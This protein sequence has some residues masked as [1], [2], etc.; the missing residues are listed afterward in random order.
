ML[1]LSWLSLCEQRVFR[2]GERYR[3]RQP[4]LTRSSIYGARAGSFGEFDIEK[5]LRQN[6]WVHKPTRGVP[7]ASIWGAPG[8][9]AGL[10]EVQR[11]GQFGV[12]E[13]GA[14]SQWGRGGDPPPR[15]R[16][17]ADSS[18]RRV[19]PRIG[20]F[21]RVISCEASIRTSQRT[22][23]SRWKMWKRSFRSTDESLVAVRR[24]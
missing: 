9:Q 17:H 22:Q 24:G 20:L 23:R 8:L 10:V 7:P 18:G 1:L 6:R 4:P 14:I 15:C 19:E 5:A 21:M 11:A 13:G 16:R 2:A 3:K 12:I